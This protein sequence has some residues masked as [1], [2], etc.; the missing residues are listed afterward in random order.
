[1][2]EAIKRGF[3]N[4]LNFQ[5]RDRRKPF[6]L[7]MLFICIIWFVISSAGG[8]Y[9]MVT[10]ITALTQNN[11]LQS[12]NPDEAGAIIMASIFGQLGQFLWFSMA[13]SVVMGFLTI[14]SFVRRLHDSDLSAWWALLPYGMLALT[15]VTVP[16]QMSYMT[17]VMQNMPAYMA[18][19]EANPGVTPQ[20]P[21]QS[22]MT[23]LGI[24]GWIQYIAFI[25]L[26]VRD[27]T[28]GPNQY[29]EEPQISY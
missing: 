16:L 8:V 21:G 15:I 4:L 18:Q 10:A 20:F 5:G 19:A 14:A 7:Y 27:S 9:W 23:L 29:G 2:G 11:A 13:I 3:G 28:R 25:I 17:E 12:T 24:P 22:Q 6:W 26:A 1:M